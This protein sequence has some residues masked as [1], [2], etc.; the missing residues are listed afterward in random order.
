MFLGVLWEFFSSVAWIYWKKALWLS[1]WLK[2]VSFMLFGLSFSSIIV[3]YILLTGESQVFVSPPYIE[4][5]IVALIVCLWLL[6]DP[7][8][9]YTYKHEKI[10]VMLPY[11]KLNTVLS[12]ILSFYIFWNV[13]IF[14]LFIALFI[15]CIIVFSSIDIHSIRIPKTLGVFLLHEVILCGSLITTGYVLL[16]LSFSDFYVLNF[17]INII[18]LVLLILYFSNIYSLFV[19]SRGFYISRLSASTFGSIGYFTSLYIISELGVISSIL[20]SFLGMIF[21]LWLGWSIL[22]DTPSKKDVFLGILI[23]LLVGVAFYFK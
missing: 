15:V 20:L 17:F 11:S 8:R 18:L 21:L 3:V 22:W 6:R 16:S 13:S 23:T 2:S 14:S 9:Q 4:I 5:C 7:L 19:Q 1:E 12:I 10:S